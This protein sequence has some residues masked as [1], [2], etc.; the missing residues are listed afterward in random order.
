[1][2]HHKVVLPEFQRLSDARERQVAVLRSGGYP[3]HQVYQIVNQ[4][5]PSRSP[6]PPNYLYSSSPPSNPY[7]NPLNSYANINMN[8]NS[9]GSV[10]QPI[11]VRPQVPTNIQSQPF[12]FYNGFGSK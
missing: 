10:T 9:T 7:V 12:N 6:S 2:S 11:P 4:F 5:P 3:D 8:M 1:M